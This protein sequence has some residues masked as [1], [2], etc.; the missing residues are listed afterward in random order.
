M[1]AKLR[2]CFAGAGDGD[3]VERARGDDDEEVGPT[4]ER[5]QGVG[6][7]GEEAYDGL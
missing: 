1:E 3:E 5:L 2:R 7:V 6:G 4:L